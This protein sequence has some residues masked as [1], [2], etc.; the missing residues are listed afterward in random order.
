LTIALTIGGEDGAFASRPHITNLL[1]QCR[2]DAV[3]EHVSLRSSHEV[4]DRIS[5]NSVG[6]PWL[7]P[8]LKGKLLTGP[9][10]PIC[11][12]VVTRSPDHKTSITPFSVTR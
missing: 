1:H 2:T 12:V 9:R 3:S 5:N 7:L 8:T 10:S 4:I 11:E 6:V